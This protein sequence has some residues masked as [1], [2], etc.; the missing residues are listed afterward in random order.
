MN[1]ESR[2]HAVADLAEAMELCF[3]KGWTDGLPVIPPTTASVTAMLEAAAVEPKQQIAFI[4]N[5][6]V[7]VTAEKVAINAVLAGCKPE[8][9]PVLI[10][11]VEAMAD[12]LYS[13]HGPATS[14]GGSAV[15]MVVNGPIA[16]ELGMNSGDNLFGPGWR[17]NATIGRAVRL[18]MRNTIGTMPGT[19]DRSSLGHA[20]KYSFCIAENEA[21]SPWP[22]FH[23]SRGFRAE[24]SVVTVFAALAPHQFSNGLSSTPEGVLDTACAHMRISA[25]SGRR[26]QYAL[27]F[28][29]EHSA[30]MKTAGWSREDVQRYCFEH[31]QTS[32][33]ELKRANLMPGAVTPDD[34]RKMS[35][36][37]ETPQD[38]LVLSAG[39]RAGVQ[40]AFVPG[41]G[42]KTS[43]QSVSR[44]IRRS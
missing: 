10:A 23:V 40:S 43:S 6:Q 31:S 19:L 32:V 21:D 33:T 27:V 44:L 37:V 11:A 26:P 16:R 36:L 8:Y 3:T 12:P 7:S 22:P 15:F 29:G 20:G 9:M 13:Y 24:Q 34:E 1:F 41:W 4:E 35:T 2:R 5:R 17:P 14:T 42:A 28:A 30:V 18:V 25:G 38:F 39:G